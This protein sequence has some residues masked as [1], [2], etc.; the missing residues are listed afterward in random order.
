MKKK[1]LLTAAVCC[2]LSAGLLAACDDNSTPPDTQTPPEE[3]GETL[4]KIEGVTFPD[5]SFV[6][7][8]TQH[9]LVV[10]GELPEGV[11]VAYTNN[12]AR[13][14]GEYEATALLSG[15]GYSSLTLTATLT[16]TRAELTGFTM[17]GATVRYD[18]EPHSLQVKGELPEGVEVR[19]ENNGQT[20]AG[21]YTVTATLSGKNYLP[22]TLTAELRILPDLSTL[23]QTVMESFGSVPDV[24][25]FFP[26]SFRLD[27][28]RAVPAASTQTDFS[29][30]VSVASL[31]D[32]GIGKQLDVVYGTV[33]SLQELMGYVNT[34]YGALTAVADTYQQYINAHP[35]DYAAFEGSTSAGGVQI[36]F[37]IL[38]TE[39][40]Y[41]LSATIGGASVELFAQP[42][43]LTYT[44]RVR[45]SQG[46]AMKFEV[47]QNSLQIG[48]NIAGRVR[49]MLEFARAENGAVA[50]YLYESL[51][52][53]VTEFQT[54]AILE[55]DGRE[56]GYVA[57]AGENG[58][59]F[60]GST[61]RVT[62]VYSAATGKYL[63]G[64]V[65][66]DIVGSYDT[67]WFPLQSV[68]GV[69]SVRAVKKTGAEALTARNPY[70][71]CLNGS[72]KAFA[73]KTVGG[74]GADMFSRRFDIEMK[75]VYF[76]T[77]DGE[78]FQ[79]VSCEIP[80]LFVQEE[81]LGTFS[82]DVSEKNEGLSLRL[83]VS[84]SVLSAT[85]AFYELL[86]PA[87]DE[88]ARLVTPEMV[89]AFIEE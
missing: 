42:Q 46:N 75:T 32:M 33:I 74:L 3:G 52:A 11:S 29:Q 56:D 13:D 1:I 49:T 12:S 86:L 30:F 27:A 83:T 25:A 20:E 64:K 51:D 45:L 59:F 62:E 61:G 78:E 17:D 15:D 38:L 6:Y 53:E 81:Y 85:D 76:Y 5:A 57:V 84:Q 60:P 70:T 36:A 89:V 50:G 71:V 72:S 10:S 2:L 88:I 18:G 39:E 65:K 77:L 87:Y 35:D 34:C 43:A 54:T 24:W 22:L 55:W 8:G 44:G 9:E 63:A 37:R 48:V 66:E 16:I 19:Y 73:P 40:E 4:E 28:E 80:M 82:A 7:D 23:A 21:A 26:Q 67:Y 47:G 69:Q 79:K 41:R 31:S 14:A 68:A 58:D